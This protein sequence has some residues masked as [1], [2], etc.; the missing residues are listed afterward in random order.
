MHGRCALHATR[1]ATRLRT[2]AGCRTIRGATRDGSRSLCSHCIE[3]GYALT[4]AL[5]DGASLSALVERGQLT[6]CALGAAVE[7]KRKRAKRTRVQL[8]LP[9]PKATQLSLFNQG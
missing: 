4:N 8:A 9:F 2:C 3:R 1:P 6:L 7:S 5:H